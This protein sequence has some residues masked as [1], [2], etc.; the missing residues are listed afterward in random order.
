MYKTFINEHNNTRIFADI[1]EKEFT[2]FF[3][4]FIII[5]GE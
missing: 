1:H 5:Y 2:L 3:V 4:L